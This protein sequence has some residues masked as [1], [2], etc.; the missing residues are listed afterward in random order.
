MKKILIFIIALLFIIFL[1]WASIDAYIGNLTSTN[2][3][4]STVYIDAE[5]T[6]ADIGVYDDQLVLPS[7][8]SFYLKYENGHVVDIVVS[9]EEEENNEN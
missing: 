1:A 2:D 6:T 8:Q 3:M 5:P 9:T 4:D 7:N